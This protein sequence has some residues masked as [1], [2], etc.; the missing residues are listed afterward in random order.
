M[1]ADELILEGFGGPS[2]QCVEGHARGVYKQVH[3]GGQLAAEDV[4]SLVGLLGD[5]TAFLAG[6]QLPADKVSLVRLYIT[7]AV[8]VQALRMDDPGLLRRLRQVTDVYGSPPD[9]PVTARC[10]LAL[11]D[12]VGE[13]SLKRRRGAMLLCGGL[14]GLRTADLTPVLDVVIAELSSPEEGRG[15]RRV[16]PAVAAR[17]TLVRWGMVTDD[18]DGLCVQVAA[19]VDPAAPTQSAL[20]ALAGLYAVG[21]RFDALPGLVGRVSTRA[22]VIGGIRDA[23]YALSFNA[24]MHR[25]IPDPDY[26][27]DRAIDVAE[28]LC[29]NAGHRKVVAELREAHRRLGRPTTPRCTPA[30]AS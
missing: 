3:D 11:V 23:F 26:P 18:L 14:V 22:D 19:A 17:E 9:V 6:P 24:R 13:E 21:E 29:T 12:G 30:G 20:R 15:L 2:L 4:K 16:A 28:G 27:F 25:S 8:R 10:L 1:F 7:M 5:S